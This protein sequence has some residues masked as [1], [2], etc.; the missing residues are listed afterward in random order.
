MQHGPQMKSGTVRRSTLKIVLLLAVLAGLAVYYFQQRTATDLGRITA[1][2]LPE[3]ARTNLVLEAGRL[4]RI[5][6]TNP[7]TGYMVEHYPDG[8]LRSRSTLTNGLLNGISMGWF[9]NGQMQV[10][11]QFKDGV[12]HG[13]RT[14]WYA[15]G[16][17]QSET[18][19]VEGKLHGTF[20]RWHENGTLS[21][22]VKFLGDQPH[23]VSRS[24]FP[25]GHLKARVVMKDGKP[26]EQQFW[27]DGENQESAPE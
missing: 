4:H 21:E 23:G 6:N 17:R 2:A 15:G 11:E 14:K 16:A 13:L 8:V 5:G 19:I 1:V 3:V 20:R 24:W 22:Q 26:G 27:K 9:T 7:F 12:S 18:P 10:V 25:S